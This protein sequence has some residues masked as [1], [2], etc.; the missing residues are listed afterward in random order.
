ML[1]RPFFV[2]CLAALAA[3]GPLAGDGPFAYRGYYF[4]LSR[5]PGYGL[6]DYRRLLDC[7]AEDGAN[8]LILWIGGGF[9]SRRYPET[10][11][12]NRNH[13][14]C[15]ENFA[16]AAIDHAHARGIRVVLGLT[17]FAYDGVNRYGAAHP[18]LGAA[19]L[20]GKPAVTG[21]IHSLGR[22]LC[23]S[24]PGAREFML[25]YA[26]ELHDD[27]YPNA[28]GL[29]LEHSDYGTCSCPECA[30]G[31]GLRREWEF[32]EALSAHV[33][34]KKPDALLLVYPQYAT[35]GVRYDPRHVIFIAPHNR[36]GAERLENPKVLSTGYW[37]ARGSWQ[38]LCREAARAGYAGIIPSMENFLHEHPYAFDTRWGPEGSAGWEDLLVRVTRLSFR[39]FSRRPDLDEAGWREAVGG[40]FFGGAPPDGAVE[41]ML[42]LHEILN[43]WSGW[44]YRGGVLKIPA[45]RVDPAALAPGS[46]EEL[47]GRTLP[48]L[49]ALREIRARSSARAAANPP[50]PAGATLAEMARIAGWVL[51]RWEGKLPDGL[52]GPR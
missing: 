49:R 52:L 17:P 26:R 7:M 40:A 4:I 18:E 36:K 37:D 5:N 48:D 47:T 31:Q 13:R 44:T 20:E 27:F 32:V 14:N 22:G 6:S 51:E 29:F 10:W 50:A 8:T 11:D 28:D 34:A 43:R 24:K 30:G 39:E 15:R 12:Y 25:A 23:P 1:F 16:G 41:D 21:G 45:Q 33:W 9:P 42:A 19:D 2:A 3:S 38:G 35:L 46:R